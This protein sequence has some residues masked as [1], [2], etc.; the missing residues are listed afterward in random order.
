[1]CEQRGEL[2]RLQAPEWQMGS[3]RADKGFVCWVH[4]LLRI[5]YDCLHTHNN[6]LGYVPRK[7][8]LF[9]LVDLY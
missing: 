5:S 8:Q 9:N 1:M 7:T 4:L 2:A 3:N 6:C